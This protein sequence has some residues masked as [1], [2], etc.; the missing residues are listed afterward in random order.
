MS[1]RAAALDFGRRASSPQARLRRQLF[2]VLTWVEQQEGSGIATIT[3]E[4][5]RLGELVVSRGRL[6]VAI[7]A[8]TCEGRRDDALD[9]GLADLIVRSRAAGRFSATA[10]QAGPAQLELA[11]A[12]LLR[13]VAADLVCMLGA[14]GTETLAAT[15]RP[16]ADDYE[17]QLTFSAGEVCAAALSTRVGALEG[18]AA[19]LVRTLEC[20]TVLVLARAA[21][22]QE[23]PYPIAARGLDHTSL[24]ELFRIG[25]AAFDL[26]GADT[27]MGD[28]EVDLQVVSVS[29]EDGAW[30]FVGAARR[31][32]VV[33]ADGE[34][35]SS[36][37]GH[38]VSIATAE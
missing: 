22:P 35:S 7:P 8:R 14:A 6:C 29:E 20:S 19:E 4:G 25:R 3:S 17:H 21:D 32:V 18:L 27:T 11:R 10:S 33:R 9:A 13:L 5:A 38:A 2:G 12:S 23:F 16:A 34:M 28:R 36:A 37:L 24:R 1:T 30:H 31:L 15:M 26:C